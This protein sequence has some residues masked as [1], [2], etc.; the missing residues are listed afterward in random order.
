MVQP[1]GIDAVDGGLCVG[2][3]RQQY[4]SCIGVELHGFG[5]EIG[6]GHMGHALVHQEEGD[7][8]RALLEL[9][10][11]VHR[12]GAGTDLHDTVFGPVMAAQVSLD[13]VEHLRL[14]VHSH[15]DWL[16]HASFLSDQLR[17]TVK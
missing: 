7:R 15:Y 3:G 10:N 12:L 6:A 14:V 9:A 11:D 17:M 8:V 4:L 1:D 13:G 5:E 16:G 2:V